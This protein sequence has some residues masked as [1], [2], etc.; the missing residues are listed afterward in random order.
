MSSSE[1]NF[2]E[3]LESS[4]ANPVDSFEP[5]DSIETTIISIGGDTIFLHLSGKSEG[6]LNAEELKDKDG[7]LTVSE[8]DTIKV[9]FLSSQGGEMRFTTRI[10][11]D[12]AGAALLENAFKN[13]IP[14][15][16]VVDKEIKGGFQIKIGDSRA[17]CP[18]SQMGLRRVENPS[19]FVGK[20]LTFKI[21]EF[22]ENGR[23]ILVSNRIILKEEH[24]KE[25]EALKDSLKLNTTIT[26]TIKEIRDFGAFVDLGAVQALLPISEISRTRVNSVKDVLSVGQ[27]IE[28]KIIKLDWQNEKIS[29]SMKALQADPWDEAAIK[30]KS[31]TKHKGKIVRITDFGAFISLEPGLDGLL[32]VSDMKSENRNSRP[33]DLVKVGQSLNVLINSVDTERKRIS[34]KQVSTEE[35]EQTFQKYMDSDDDS[36]GETY[37]PFADLLKK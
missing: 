22:K 17:F 7:N 36:D 19:D 4:F 13:A 8:G 30:Y 37:N 10:S 2:E 24:D 6:V 16:G 26:G 15:E 5:G 28:A 25:V 14:V 31:G 34:L 20:H 33:Q 29:L 27:E 12:K 23:N 21:T 32:H 11:G 3:L 35:E 18:F 9:Y 1:E